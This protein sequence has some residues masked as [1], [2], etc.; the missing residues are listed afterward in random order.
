MRLDG[1]RR[2]DVSVKEVVQMKFS[3]QRIYNKGVRF[4]DDEVV[5]A[6]RIVGDLCTHQERD[7]NSGVS[8]NVAT[9]GDGNHGGGHLLPPL[10]NATLVKISPLSM[11]MSGLER[12]ESGSGVMETRQEWWIRPVDGNA[13][14]AVPAKAMTQKALKL[15]ELGGNF[16]PM[17]SLINGTRPR[18]QNVPLSPCQPAL[19]PYKVLVQTN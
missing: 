4:N 1:R 15:P 3:V 12:A 11:V 10:Y 6:P 16:R 2:R 19:E 18:H 5:N 8:M 14:K 9:L 7:E 17:L 13:E